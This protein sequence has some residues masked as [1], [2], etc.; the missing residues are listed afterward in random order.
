MKTTSTKQRAHSEMKTSG[1]LRGNGI[2]YAGANRWDQE[3]S[4]GSLP[5]QVESCREVMERDG[6]NEVQP[7]ILDL[8]SGLD[9]SRRG[10]REL[11]KL[12]KQGRIGYVY[13]TGLDR[14]G[15]D[16]MKTLNLKYQPEELGVLVRTIE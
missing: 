14:L 4:L 5:I 6:V 13:T 10:L 15:R 12:A 9:F 7:P 8:S 3:S 11:I 1:S 2:V 16:L